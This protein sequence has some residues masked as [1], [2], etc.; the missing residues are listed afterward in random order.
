MPL[1]DEL[2][3]QAYTLLC[4]F[5]QATRNLLARLLGQA[6]EGGKPSASPGEKGGAAPPAR[7][8]LSEV[9]AVEKQTPL[10]PPPS[11]PNPDDPKYSG[12]RE[13]YEK[14]KQAHAAA[15][16]AFQA[17]V[18]ARGA[19]IGQLISNWLATA[20]YVM[21]QELLDQPKDTM[22]IFKPEVGPVIVMRHEHVI[23][24]LERTD[25]FTVDPYASE[26]AKAMDDKTKNPE[27]L[28]HFMLGTDDDGLYR[29]DDVIMRR[30]V[31][32]DDAAML[33]ALTRQEAERLTRKAREEARGEIDV[34]T[35]IAKF[36]P[37]RIVGDY[38]GVPYY[39]AGE[40]SSLPGLRG[41][42]RFPLDDELQKVFTFQKIQ[43][44]QIP[45]PDDL[46][47]WV[48][49]AFRN[50]FNNF[51]PAHPL[52]AQ[53][54]DRGLI[55]TEYLTAYIHEL[56]KFHKACLVRGE[57]VPDTMLTRLL[58]L[59][60]ALAS[61]QGEALEQEFG[62][63]L[64]APLLAGELSRRLTDSMIRSNV[65]GTVVGA[66]VN[67][68]EATARTIDSILKLKDGQYTVLN[69]SGYQR[70]VDLANLPEDAP[71]A[72]ESLKILRRYALEA[73]RLQ[74][75]GEI[76]LRL[77]VKDNSEL[78]GVPIH[79]GTLVFVSHGAAMRDPDAIPNPLAFDV[80]RDERPV[81][82]RGDQERAKEA[83]QSRIYL[84]HGY[85]RHKCLGRY[86]SEITLQESLRAMLRLGQLKRLSELQMDE[87]NLYAVSLRV[88]F[89]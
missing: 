22:P 70:A 33:T 59:Q 20:P 17:T 12:N 27:A 81:A 42:D 83:P 74:P 7:G 19:A 25:L 31:S 38:L 84:Q 68:Q 71:Q 75:Q 87:Q 21:L 69:D 82:Y 16:S 10:A 6:G 5:H 30:V 55:A 46:L 78:G 44:G 11:E 28:T 9:A 51:N 34:V 3:K 24:C 77:C 39:A 32:R 13:A 60:M 4:Q 35:T 23:K 52:F 76:L 66:V 54:R 58:R 80:S 8:F 2:K 18:R 15:V 88:G 62:V 65:F 64:G 85:G 41:G 43:E 37:L 86:A 36:V 48:K 49:D 14:D 50:I 1:L 29:L 79:K 45:T 72:A 73:L 26:M 40:P 57:A 53:F 67:P 47:E 89:C 61:D 56:L 63:L